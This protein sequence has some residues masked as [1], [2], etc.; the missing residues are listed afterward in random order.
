MVAAFISAEGTAT[1]TNNTYEFN[2]KFIGKTISMTARNGFHY[3][4]LTPV[5]SGV[6]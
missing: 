2:N 5:N 3:I 6:L 1:I 4:L